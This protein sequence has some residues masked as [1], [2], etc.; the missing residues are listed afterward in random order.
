MSLTN[1]L[2]YLY[3]LTFSNNSKLMLYK[4]IYDSYLIYSHYKRKVVYT[5]NILNTLII[6]P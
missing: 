5:F 3:L 2:C 1:K 6:K 4:Y